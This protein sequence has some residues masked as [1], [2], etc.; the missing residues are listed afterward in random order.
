MSEIKKIGVL[1]S[2]GDAPG[3][4]AAVRAVARTAIHHNCDA[5]AIYQGYKGMIEGHIEKLESR[6]VSGIIQ[7]GGTVIRTARSEEFRK[8]EGRAKAYEN[9]KK[10]GIDAVVAIG[11]DGTFKGADA[12]SNE[13]NIPFIGI[14]GTIDNDIYGTDY[15]IG[16]DTALNTVVDAVDKI[17]DTASSHDR[18]FFIEVMGREAG[19]VALMSGIASGAEGILIPEVEH[20][21]LKVINFLKDTA[22][23]RKSYI[24]MVAE[25]DEEGHA[26]DLANKVKNEFPFLDVRTSILGH[27]QR[28]GAPSCH[29]RVTASRMGVAAVEAI[30]HGKKAIMIGLVNGEINEMPLNQTVKMHKSVNKQL[31]KMLDMLV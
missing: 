26:I 25:G 12:M 9:L 27:I 29:D 5:Y 30:M 20:Q 17:R 8:E 2:G 1:T 3:M 31:Y 22:G 7:K 10:H 13:F 19:F 21:H 23:E 18:V 6:T 16:Y 4:N 15:T 11:G 24:F 28:G 14:P